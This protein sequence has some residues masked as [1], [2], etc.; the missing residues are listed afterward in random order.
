[1]TDEEIDK[2]FETAIERGI[3]F[4]KDDGTESEMNELVNKLSEKVL[5]RLE[6]LGIASMF[7]FDEMIN[8]FHHLKLKPYF[9]N[10]V[11][12]RI[13]RELEKKQELLPNGFQPK[14]PSTYANLHIMYLKESASTYFKGLTSAEFSDDL[15]K[16]LTIIN[17]KILNLI[18]DFEVIFERNALLELKKEV[19][20]EIDLTTTEK[21]TR[22]RLEFLEPPEKN[23][24]EDKNNLRPKI[25]LHMI[26][27]YGKLELP[28]D[29]QIEPIAKFFKGFLG[30]DLKKIRGILKAPIKY[31]GKNDAGRTQSLKYLLSDLQYVSQQ[32]SKL[33]FNKHFDYV[34]AIIED[35]ENDLDEE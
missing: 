19:E 25:L 26:L 4:I 14:D 27:I 6:H 31:E 1:M 29:Q 17:R 33:K 20:I 15:A 23:A 9:A 11:F 21:E 22:K 35:L 12:I 3:T 16:N 32:L 24:E 30:G 28:N 34:Q 8:L 10:Q 13:K 2:L 18:D 5:S 7:V